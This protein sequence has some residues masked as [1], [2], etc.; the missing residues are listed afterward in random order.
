MRVSQE[1][2]LTFFRIKGQSEVTVKGRASR[3][4]LAVDPNTNT[5]VNSRKVQCTVSEKLLTD[6]AY[7]TRD[8]NGNVNLVNSFVRY[9]DC[10]GIGRDYKITEIYPD[11]TIGL[12]VCTLGSLKQ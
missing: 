11:D 1:T 8:S 3:I 7:Q 5:F 9:A 2:P 4:H 10:T 6:L 12:I